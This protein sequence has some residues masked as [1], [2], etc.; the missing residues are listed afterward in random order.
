MNGMYNVPEDPD[1]GYTHYQTVR[2]LPSFRRFKEECAGLAD[3]LRQTVRSF[4]KANGIPDY[5][6]VL[7]EVFGRFAVGESPSDRTMCFFVGDLNAFTP[8]FFRLLQARVLSEYPLWRLLAQFEGIEV[9]LYPSGVWLG[10]HWVEGAFDASYPAF[11]KWLASARQHRELRLGPLRRQLAYVR[12][13]IPDAMA[14]AIGNQYALLGAF[15]R[16]QPHLPGHAIWLLQT[17][18]DDEL[19]LDVGAAPVRNSAVA[20]DGTIYPQFSRDFWAETDLN[21]PFWLCTYVIEP[22]MGK[23]L[24][25]R[26]AKDE[27]VGMIAISKV[28]PD[29]E[30]V[31][32]EGMSGRLT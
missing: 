29:D 24:R 14:I 26:N 15:D 20:A 2:R 22:G 7:Q 28:I 27:I 5:N 18:R 13:T 11:Q 16:Y 31:T 19:S 25:M 1:S 32:A 6:E 21:P 9:G 17:C 30:L 8:E 23:E 3:R 12:R 4:L 10:D